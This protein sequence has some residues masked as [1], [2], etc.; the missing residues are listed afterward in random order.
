MSPIVEDVER[1]EDRHYVVPIERSRGCAFFID[2]KRLEERR[3]THGGNFCLVLWSYNE[4]NDDYFVIPYQVMAPIF[5]DGSTIRLAGDGMHRGWI[6][7]VADDN[8]LS[9]E[10]GRFDVQI[11]SYYRKNDLLL[12]L[13]RGN[14]LFSFTQYRLDEEACGWAPYNP[15]GPVEAD[16]LMRLQDVERRVSGCAY[17]ARPGAGRIP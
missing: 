4:G 10:G 6:G 5:R 9:I 15:P 8:T 14:D 7:T 11:G 16:E 2:S 17:S 1:L 3:Q 12:W 13:T